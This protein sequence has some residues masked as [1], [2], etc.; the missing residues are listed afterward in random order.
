MSLNLLKTSHPKSAVALT[1]L[2]LL[3]VGISTG[4]SLSYP[5]V[6]NQHF[7]SPTSS[8]ATTKSLTTSQ[9]LSIWWNSY[10]KGY[11]VPLSAMIST[12][13]LTS[14]YFAHGN[15]LSSQTLNW[16]KVALLGQF[17]LTPFTLVAVL[18]VNNRLKSLLDSSSDGVPVNEQEVNTLLDKWTKLH[19]VRVA[20]LV[21]SATSTIFAFTL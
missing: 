5:L 8:K 14:L 3:S 1:T 4:L 2:G 16:I 9:R 19:L 6:I 13:S 7:V 21:V 12:I 18:P 17:A 20:S 10:R 11:C 15:K